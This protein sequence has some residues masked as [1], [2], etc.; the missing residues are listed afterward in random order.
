MNKF[1]TLIFVTLAAICSFTFTSCSSNDE[2]V[3]NTVHRTILVYMAANNSL[4]SADADASDI[5]EML[6][7]AQNGDFNGG[8]LMLYHADTD[9]NATLSEVT[10]NGLVQL[11]DYA[12]DGLLSVQSERMRKVIAD[13]KLLSPAKEYGLILWSHGDGWLQNGIDESSASKSK[14]KA[15]GSENS[16]KMNIT[17][18]ASALSGEGF[19]FVYFDCCYMAAVE[20]EYELR[21]VTPYIVASASELPVD[22]MPYDKNLRYLFADNFDLVGSA[23]NTFN[24]YN[25]QV[26]FWQTCTMSVVRTAGL[27]D[28][29]AATRKIYQSAE[30]C[31]PEGYQPQKYMT[32][33]RCYYYDL[34]DYIRAIASDEDYA[35]WQTALSNCIIYEAAT[36]TLWQELNIDTH[37]GLST[38]I[39]TSADDEIAANRN[40]NTLSWYND[41][42]SYL[43]H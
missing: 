36:P 38:Y 39:F 29:A 23:T 20:V 19:A 34:A 9:G 1:K 3:D 26:G 24:T 27:D 35:N 8:K 30:T 17:T 10:A 13:T 4:G 33:N 14:F 40:Y 42:V 21:N 16:K 7:A 25:E 41:V 43:F 5:E 32:S 11:K 31:Y 15:W 2:P 28:L 37:C 18:L 12:D 22:G 6:T